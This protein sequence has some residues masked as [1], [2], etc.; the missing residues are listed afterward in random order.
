MHIYIYVIILEKEVEKYNNQWS[1]FNFMFEWCGVCVC[2]RVCV[3]VSIV[4]VCVVRESV[5]ECVCMCVCECVC[6]CVCACVY[7]ASQVR[8]PCWVS[9]SITPRI[10]YWSWTEWVDCLANKLH[11]SPAS[12]SS[13][14]GYWCMFLCLAF[15]WGMGMGTQVPGASMTTT[16]PT[17]PSPQL[18]NKEHVSENYCL[19]S[20]NS[21]CLFVFVV[22]G[23][24]PWP[25]A[26]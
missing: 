23:A 21:M 15:T 22:L 2:I 13:A 14:L 8:G 4:W 11:P 10:S 3:C 19:S 1:V 20:E 16:L 18:L 6:V 25:R 26:G 7:P 17:E 24:D 5:C 12:A 9:S